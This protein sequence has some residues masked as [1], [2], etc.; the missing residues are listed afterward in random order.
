MFKYHP[1][2]VAYLLNYLYVFLSFYINYL[3]FSDKLLE[4]KKSKIED[5]VLD[6]TFTKDIYLKKSNE[7]ESEINELIEPTIVVHTPKFTEKEQKVIKGIKGISYEP[8]NSS[9]KLTCEAKK[10]TIDQ[11][12]ANDLKR[13]KNRINRMYTQIQA[14]LSK[15]G[16]RQAT[17]GIHTIPDVDKTNRKVKFRLPND[18]RITIGHSS[19]CLYIGIFIKNIAYANFN[20]Y[21]NKILRKEYTNNLI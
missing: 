12:T 20:S 6:G 10:H 4:D 21:N 8:K 7:I 9:L 16:L 3:L 1:F 13:H 17:F 11:L 15:Y 14:K 5:F 19:R 2:I 18:E